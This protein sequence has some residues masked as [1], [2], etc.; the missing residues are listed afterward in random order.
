MVMGDVGSVADFVR[1]VSYGWDLLAMERRIYG[2]T[3]SYARL[4]LLLITAGIFCFL[5]RKGFFD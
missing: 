1:I 4:V 5:L 2:F 3:F